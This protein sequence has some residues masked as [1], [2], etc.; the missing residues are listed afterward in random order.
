MVVPIASAQLVS[1]SFRSTVLIGTVL[2]TTASVVGVGS[3]FYAD[4]PS[5]G[6]IVLVSIAIFAVLAAY[7][8]LRERLKRPSAREADEPQAH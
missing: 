4:T 6:T 1:R 7:S 2:G 3:S 5:G 8:A